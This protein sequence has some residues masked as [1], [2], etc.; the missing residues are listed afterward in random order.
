MLSKEEQEYHV[1]KGLCFKCHKPG[2]RS[3][4][5]PTIKRKIAKIEV[6]YEDDDESDDEPS[7]EGVLSISTIIMNMEVEQEP[8]V[9]Q[10]K[11]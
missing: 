4:K 7:K 9:L 5:C 1:K 3:F 11:V 2:H 10:I 6:E 8:T